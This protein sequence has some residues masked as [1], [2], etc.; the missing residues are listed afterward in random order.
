MMMRRSHMLHSRRFFSAGPF[1]WSQ[2]RPYSSLLCTRANVGLSLAS[3]L[4][5]TAFV[6]CSWSRL[7]LDSAAQDSN[8]PPESSR[9]HE[10]RRTY[11]NESYTRNGSFNVHVRHPHAYSQI[12]EQTVFPGDHT[13]VAR[14]DTAKNDS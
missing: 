10:K 9:E 6:G 12:F 8:P 14:Y 1:K 5:L 2:R 4:G 3:F 11:Y 13:G 7:N